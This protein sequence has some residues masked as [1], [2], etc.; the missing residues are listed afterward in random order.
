MLNLERVRLL[1]SSSPSGWQTWIWNH[2]QFTGWFFPQME[3]KLFLLLLFSEEQ[4]AGINIAEVSPTWSCVWL[5]S[6]YVCWLVEWACLFT[7]ML[8]TSSPSPMVIFQKCGAIK[9]GCSIYLQ[10]PGSTGAAESV[11]NTEGFISSV[12]YKKK[13]KRKRDRSVAETPACCFQFSSVQ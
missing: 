6:A 11:S 4:L 8:H 3:T 2:E 12:V 1:S 9:S 10:A 7:H 5:N 13:K